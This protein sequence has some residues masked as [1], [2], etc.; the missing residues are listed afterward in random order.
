VVHTVFASNGSTT[1]GKEFEIICSF[2]VRFTLRQ[3][4]VDSFRWFLNGDALTVNMQRSKRFRTIEN[5]PDRLGVWT[6]TLQI[7]PLTSRDSGTFTCQVNYGGMYQSSQS[8]S[9]QITLLPNVLLTPA[10]LTTFNAENVSLVCL[11]SYPSET[12]QPAGRRIVLEF[13]WFLND[14]LLSSDGTM[15]SITTD[16]QADTSS[17]MLTVLNSSLVHCSVRLANTDASRDSE[18]C[19]IR[20]INGSKDKPETAV[21][22]PQLIGSI[23]WSL[24]AANDVNIEMCSKPLIGKATRKCD[25]NGNWQQPDYSS[26]VTNSLNKIISEI[27]E[28]EDG[29]GVSNSTKMAAITS[30]LKD[31]VSSLLNSSDN[32]SFFNKSDESSGEV[33]NIIESIKRL[34][35]VR[36]QYPEPIQ[37]SEIADILQ[38]VD[39]VLGPEFANIWQY[40]NTTDSFSAVSLMKSVDVYAMLW[41]HNLTEGQDAN[42]TTESFVVQVA[43]KR[44]SSSSNITYPRD[45]MSV[46][47]WWSGTGDRI[48][49]FENN[50]AGGDPS[51]DIQYITNVY[52]KNLHEMM[53]NN[54]FINSRIMSMAADPLSRDNIT[55]SLLLH[56]NKPFDST[57][58][59]NCDFWDYNKGKSGEWSGK[60]CSVV[61]EGTNETHTMCQCNHLT[62][63]AILM[64]PFT[65]IDPRTAVILSLIS[66]VGCIVSIISMTMTIVL[67]AMRWSKVKS[68]HAVVIINLCIALI[69]AN[70]IFLA[71]VNRTQSEVGCKVVAA[72]L[73]YFF[74]ASFFIML[75]EG[76]QLVLYVIFVFHQRRKTET[77]LLLFA[78]WFIPMVIVGVSLGITRTEGYGANPG[79]SDSCWL[80]LENGVFWAFA[81]PALCVI[82]INLI[83]FILVLRRICIAK[84]RI[85]KDSARDRIKETMWNIMAIT[86]VLGIMWIFGV[87]SV[88][89]DLIAF[90]YIFAVANSLQGLFI[91]IFHGLCNQR[92][93]KNRYSLKTSKGKK[94][95]SKPPLDTKQLNK[96]DITVVIN[97]SDHINRHSLSPRSHGDMNPNGRH[98]DNYSS[99]NGSSSESISHFDSD[100][101][102]IGTGTTFVNSDSGTSREGR[103]RNV[104]S[105]QL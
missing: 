40:L 18:D 84:M 14:Q 77:A 75:A 90:Q 21:C 100:F 53:P 56:I 48:T 36:T 38:T 29:I 6:S 39:I 44:R 17:L 5:A 47:D 3:I 72:L 1:E 4:Q 88:N 79:K 13:D 26:C 80:S 27:D 50:T 104:V 58:K 85:L 10:T 25:S 43:A 2:Q 19:A 22:R 28:V 96:D 87:L 54:Y 16:Q 9:L 92:N 8:T 66:L 76:V 63:F 20:M 11:G 70:I 89:K 105:S 42:M 15:T 82:C 94:I 67:Y 61:S 102:S 23:L 57:Y 45:P 59:R 31:Y 97:P 32:E 71:G 91:F 86:P 62:N 34:A 51:N 49:L 73:H 69:I 98:N 101:Q 81:G 103:K 24:T 74:L 78:A 60:G 55:V 99:T 52:Y 95:S 30:E 37:Q 65:D 7:D 12:V 33:I 68:H 41:A 64:S 93:N 35:D 83:I 46:V